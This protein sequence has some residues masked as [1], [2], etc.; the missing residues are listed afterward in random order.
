MMP[1]DPDT[2]ETALY[3]VIAELNRRLLF[4]DS[5]EYRSTLREIIENLRTQLVKLIESTPTYSDTDIQRMRARN[6]L[7]GPGVLVP[8]PLPPRLS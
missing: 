2:A 5:Q 7:G 6:E 3:R 1:P 4:I 8:G